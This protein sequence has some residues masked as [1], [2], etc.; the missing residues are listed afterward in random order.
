M[1]QIVYCS[2]GYLINYIKLYSACFFLFE[3]KKKNRKVTAL[4]SLIMLF[5]TVI[6]SVFFDLS[7]ITLLY[8][9][10]STVGVSLCLKNKKRII[11]VIAIILLI[12]F[13]DTIIGLLII[14][15]ADLSYEELSNHSYF[16]ILINLILEIV[17]VLI[18]VLKNKKKISL[19]S[20]IDLNVKDIVIFALGLCSIA[21]YLSSIMMFIMDIDSNSY[22]KISTVSLS[23][24]GT[25]FMLICFILL[26]TRNRNSYYKKESA[27][28][29]ELLSSQE[30]YYLVLLNREEETRKF[31]HD[32]KNHMLC[33]RTLYNNKEYT[34]LENYF[35]KLQIE[36]NDLSS[37]VNTGDK[38]TNVILN[39]VRSKYP[40]VKCEWVGTLD[41]RLKIE[42]IDICTIFS[43]ILINAFEAANSSQ[44]KSVSIS[45]RFL[46]TTLFI[47]TENTYNNE[48][49]IKNRQLISTKKDNG[50]GYGIKNIKECIEHY[51]GN[52][53]YSYDEDLFV[54][55]L[56]IPNAINE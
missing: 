41:N 6:I 43:N 21:I 9:V 32:I 4:L 15:F 54:T 42:S 48:P 50:H 13:F 30:K 7:K 20:T 34:E 52:L 18:V 5:L 3:Y 47:Q 29:H 14:S 39:D 40:N 53:D 16:V 33:I 22:K 45:V 51:N 1:N 17:I 35:D 49:I 28:T 31:R 44:E 25:I 2:L 27:M 12:N 11:N 46:G 19:Y 10:I 8:S 38:L 37:A 23:I 36:L 24:G 26:Y 55:N 56:I